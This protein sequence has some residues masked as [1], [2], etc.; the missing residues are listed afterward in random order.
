MNSIMKSVFCNLEK[1]L[2]D[3][4]TYYLLVKLKAE[5]YFIVALTSL[6]QVQSP[7]SIEDTLMIMK[8]MILQIELQR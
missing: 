3:Y 7:C 5:V 2:L 8:K 4:H 1:E 6:W